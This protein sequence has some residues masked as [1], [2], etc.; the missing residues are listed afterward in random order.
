VIVNER[1]NSSDPLSVALPLG[2]KA[3]D[4]N[5]LGI[6]GQWEGNVQLDGKTIVVLHNPRKA[7]G[8]LQ[9]ATSFSVVG[10]ELHGYVQSA[11]VGLS[12][13]FAQQ[14]SVDCTRPFRGCSLAPEQHRFANWDQGGLGFPPSVR[15]DA[16]SP[17]WPVTQYGRSTELWILPNPDVAAVLGADFGNGFVPV[18]A[19]Y[20][21]AEPFAEID[22]AE[23][24]KAD[25]HYVDPALPTTG[26]QVA[27]SPRVALISETD[28]QS[29]VAMGK[30]E[31][32]AWEPPS[33]DV[34]IIASALNDPQA[35]GVH[36]GSSA[37][38]DDLVA[39]VLIVAKSPRSIEN[40]MDARRVFVVPGPLHIGLGAAIVGTDVSIIGIGPD[41]FSAGVCG[42]VFFPGVN[43]DPSRPI[44]PQ[45][46]SISQ[47]GYGTDRFAFGQPRATL[48]WPIQFQG[49]QSVEVL[50]CSR[51]E[52]PRPPPPPLPP[53]FKVEY[54]NGLDD[55]DNGLIDES[56]CSLAAC[57]TCVPVA[58]CGA[59]RCVS[60]PD[61]C[62]AI[63]QCA[64]P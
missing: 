40:A 12:L 43:F 57:S 19:R 11:L 59:R 30:F 9:Q 42:P 64:C 51:F 62:G 52:P 21:C 31:N 8:A 38:R 27:L 3:N 44:V 2:S 55:N 47:P 7:V 18:G 45:P 29:A 20:V 48:R 15:L 39:D 41:R 25:G 60:I 13:H 4:K 5:A 54:C 61:G 37:P 53:V 34:A 22:V 16:E 10:G 14:P 46:L 63:V 36:A 50:A 58:D 28:F 32:K 24:E 17:G 26:P 6:T 23:C 33:S 35:L 56:A 49:S 1:F